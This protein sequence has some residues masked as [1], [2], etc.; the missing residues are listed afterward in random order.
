MQGFCPIPKEKAT[1]STQVA[2]MPSGVHVI[3]DRD[4]TQ[5]VSRRTIHSYRITVR[6]TGRGTWSIGEPQPQS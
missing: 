3:D 5:I 1:P 4:L 2:T 6:Y